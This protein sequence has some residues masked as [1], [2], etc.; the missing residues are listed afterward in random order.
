MY[1]NVKINGE[2]SK[3]L[4]R[5]ICTF[6]ALISEL[7]GDT[8]TVGPLQYGIYGPVRILQPSGDFQFY[9][10]IFSGFGGFRIYH[11]GFGCGGFR[12]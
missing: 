6:G 8:V 11:K 3:N 2:I 4:M 12:N 10:A 5:F 1:F 7:Y 9:P